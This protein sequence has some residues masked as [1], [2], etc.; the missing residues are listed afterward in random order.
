M[1][2]FL[3]PELPSESGFPIARAGYPFILISVFV[4]AIAALAGWAWLTGLGLCA[5]LFCFWFFRDPDRLIPADPEAMVSPADGKVIVAQRVDSHPYGDG[6][7]FQISIFMSVFNVHVNRIPFDGTVREI[8]YQPGRFFNASLDKASKDNE[9][10]A[11][12]IETPSSVKFWT[13]QVAG[14]VARRIICRVREGDQVSRGV[15]FGIIC[16]GSR[17]DLYLPEGFAC[18]VK[19]GERV[20]A[21]TTTLGSLR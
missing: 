16:F 17:L 21:G 14:L 20:S 19:V 9:R 12:L 8:R 13:V 10:N 3:R 7:A 2:A 18:S 4:T 15:R 6:P 1:N 11:L 5:S